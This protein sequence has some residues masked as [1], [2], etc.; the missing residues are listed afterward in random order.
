MQQHGAAQDD[1]T[2]QALCQRSADERPGRIG[3][4]G[5]EVQQPDPGIRLPER[6]LDRADEGRDEQPGPA[7]RDEGQRPDQPGGQALSATQGHDARR[8]ARASARGGAIPGLCQRAATADGRGDTLTT[9]PASAVRG[10][11]P[12]EGARL[13]VT[14]GIDLERARAETPGVANVIHLNNAGSALPP[15]PVTDRMIRYLEREAAIGGYEAEAEAET[16]LDGVYTS[17]ARLVGGARDE[18]AVCENA[19]RAWDAAFYSLPFGPGDRILT[20]GVEYTSNF[21]A[22]LQVARRTGASVEVIPDAPTGELDVDALERMLDD[23]VRLI[24]IT[25]VPSHSG[26]V[27]PAAAVGRVT[28]ARGIPYLLDACQSIGQL[29]IDVEQIGCDMLTATS[30][31]FLRG[32]RGMGFL[33]IRRALADTLEP[34][35]IDYRSARWTSRLDY[36]LEPGAR[37]F[38]NWEANYAAKLGLGVAVD[39]ALDWGLDAIET[40]V[41]A[42]ADRLRD[43]LSA[44]P[45]VT[46]HDPGRRRSGI[47]TF[48]VAGREPAAI[49]AQLRTRR[50]NVSVSDVAYHRLG[51]ESRGLGS[52][53]RASVHYYNSEDETD[54]LV[55]ALAG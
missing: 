48:G 22:M 28:R 31:K 41:V 49:E 40:R 15:V 12:K 39:Y 26:L 16:E 35:F 51:L 55:E 43:G 25:H 38:E 53:V 1:P 45:G 37:R 47:V 4:A 30:R 54:A 42:L 29:A 2:T 18:I 50:I 32:P 6:R 14:D 36:E 17:I 23:R 7:D 33:Y 34:P 5:R 3:H 10:P 27:N 8:A 52:V 21:L 44:L 20:S 24:A 13:T 19:T 9:D 46:V 11:D